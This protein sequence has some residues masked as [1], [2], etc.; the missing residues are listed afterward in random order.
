M[1]P[2]EKNDALKLA[3]A[4][5]AATAGGVIGGSIWALVAGTA[6]FFTA[7]KVIE[8]NLGVAGETEEAILK[9]AARDLNAHLH[10]YGTSPNASHEVWTF[11]KA[12]NESGVGPRLERD[13]FFNQDTQEALRLALQN[14]QL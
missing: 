8:K 12:W 11:Q 7:H 10:H 14:Y 2:K 9:M 1:T 6:G 3:A 5:A 4:A 13:G